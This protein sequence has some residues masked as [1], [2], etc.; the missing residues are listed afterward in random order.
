MSEKP[1][2][3]VIAA[4]RRQTCNVKVARR[5]RSKVVAVLLSEVN[6]SGATSSIATGYSRI[7]DNT[8]IRNKVYNLYNPHFSSIMDSK[9]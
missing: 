4:F 5:G 1:F 6:S 3:R 8:N 9:E 7:D 2:V